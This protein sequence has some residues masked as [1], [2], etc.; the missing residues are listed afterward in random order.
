MLE[1]LKEAEIARE[2]DE[3]PVGAVMLYKGKIVAA[4][5]NRMKQLKNPL[6]HAEK[7]IIERVLI[8]G[9]DPEK[10]TLVV[11]LEPC[12]M[13]AGAIDLVNIRKVYFGA[14]DSKMGQIDNNHCVLSQKKIE[15]YGGYF[16]DMSGRLLQDFF[17]SLR[18]RDKK[19]G[20]IKEKKERID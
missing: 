7:L 8:D 12:L 5:H 13:C 19:A 16:E 18:K 1:A 4:D 9:F 2:E 17:I 15:T 11:T 6:A 10:C 14:Y 20:F 3:V